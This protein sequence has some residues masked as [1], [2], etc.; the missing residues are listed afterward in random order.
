[1]LAPTRHLRPCPVTLQANTL[2]IATHAVCHILMHLQNANTLFQILA[3]ISG[4]LTTWIRCL[5][6][7]AFGTVCHLTKGKFSK[8]LLSGGRLRRWFLSLSFFGISL[9]AWFFT[10]RNTLSF[11]LGIFAPL[12]IVVLC[13]VCIAANSPTLL[14][15]SFGFRVF[16]SFTWQ[17]ALI[18]LTYYQFRDLWTSDAKEYKSL[19]P[20]WVFI[21]SVMIYFSLTNDFFV[22]QLAPVKKR[23]KKRKRPDHL[24]SEF[25]SLDFETSIQIIERTLHGRD[26]LIRVAKQRSDLDAI[27]ENAVYCPEFR[28]CNSFGREFSRG[29][30]S[31]RSPTFRM[32]QR[33]SSPSSKL[34]LHDISDEFLNK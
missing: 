2:T 30:L 4:V 31:F 34:M 19:P 15:T 11:M 14:Q 6:F 3:T 29:P 24:R 20:F 27:P 9:G 12:I 28:E 8:K 18:C 26:F 21:K 13:Q 10:M 22:M 33:Q 7:A 32:N 1:M 23:K 5:T 25:L 17:F 16:S